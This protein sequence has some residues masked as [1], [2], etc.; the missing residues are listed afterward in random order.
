M[1]KLF[2][3]LF[4]VLQHNFLQEE[5]KSINVFALRKVK[6]RRG[7]NYVSTYVDWQ[8]KGGGDIAGVCDSVTCRGMEMM[9]ERL[10]CYY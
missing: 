10:C 5:N 7:L 9:T 1:I 2:N 4:N 3:A 8:S 6:K